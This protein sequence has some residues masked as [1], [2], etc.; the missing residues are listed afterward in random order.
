MRL[1]HDHARV[2]RERLAAGQPFLHAARHHGLKQ[3]AQKVALAKTAVAILR[4]GRI[5][6][7]LAVEPQPAEPTIGQIEV[8]LIAQPPFRANAEAIADNQH[9][10]HQLGIDRGSSHLAVI[11]LKMR[12]NLRQIDEAVDLAQEVIVRDMTLNAEA[13]EQRLLHHPPLAHHGVRP[14]FTVKSESA[15][16]RRRKRLLQQNR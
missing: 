9:P 11:G 8:D 2:D 12:P 15:A 6:R 13:V 14:R 3:L 4:E 1:G 10:D 7:N 5:V 16:R